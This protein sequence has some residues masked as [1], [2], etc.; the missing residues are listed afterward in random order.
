MRKYS[1]P[2]E[3]Q[4][5]LAGLGFGRRRRGF[6]GGLILLHDDGLAGGSGDDNGSLRVGGGLPEDDGAAWGAGV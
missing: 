5:G 1:V 3:E 4:G 2:L 6:S